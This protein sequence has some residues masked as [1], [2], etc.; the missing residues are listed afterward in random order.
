ML[1][2]IFYAVRLIWWY[3]SFVGLGVGVVPQSAQEVFAIAQKWRD[4]QRAARLMELV[5]LIMLIMILVGTRTMGKVQPQLM[6]RNLLVARSIRTNLILNL[7]SRTILL[8]HDKILLLANGGRVPSQISL[9]ISMIKEIIIHVKI[10]QQ[11]RLH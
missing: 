5:L 9:L 6:C 2:A 1:I 4:S 3:K 11:R 8:T 10:V 7:T